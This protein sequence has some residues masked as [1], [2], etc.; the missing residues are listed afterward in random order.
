MAIW[1]GAYEAG[2][3]QY[4]LHEGRGFSLS[5]SHNIPRAENGAWHTGAQ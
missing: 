5:C 4:E 3:V 2:P 1:F